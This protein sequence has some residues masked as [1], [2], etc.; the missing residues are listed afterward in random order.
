MPVTKAV[1]PA[2]G[3]GTRML[4]AA[5]AVPKEML[6]VLDKPVVQYVVEEAAAA[7]VDDVLLVVSREKKAIEDHFD[8]HPELDAR[9]AAGGKSHLLDSVA[10]LIARVQIHTVRQ[11]E[12]LGLGHA[13]LQAER[14]V[15]AAPFH[16][17]LGDAIFTGDIE[18]TRQLAAAY[19]RF[20]GCIIGLEEVEADKVNRYGIAG[21]QMLDADTPAAD[22][23]SDAPGGSRVLR[24]DQL[25]E[26]PTPA[27]APSRFAIAARYLLTPDIFP[28]LGN[29]P[30]GKGGEIQ[31]TD[32][33]RELLKT[34]PVYGVVLRARRHDIGNPADWLMT[35]LLLAGRD[36]TLWRQ[37][38][39]AV[40]AMLESDAA[41]TL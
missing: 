13:V 32:A 20:G 35:N 22:T 24:I 7:G 27:E 6:P 41:P 26:K 28:A 29:T 33:L 2:A 30:P 38:E 21:G 34:R 10:K 19:E 4:P 31:L 1:I 16:C 14:H 11:A 8:R 25:V 12:Q 17:L 37:I 39:P 3:L 18:P 9:L 5:K 15:G 40:R 36:P 23:A